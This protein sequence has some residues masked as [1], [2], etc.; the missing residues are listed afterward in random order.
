MRKLIIL[1]ILTS[2]TS[3]AP[4]W[5]EEKPQAGDFSFKTSGH[6]VNLFS[7]SQTTSDKDYASDLQ[8]LRLQLEAGYGDTLKGLLAYDHSLL[9]SS[10]LKTADF[11]TAQNRKRK[12]YMDL[13]QEI[14]REGNLRWE[15]SLYRAYLDYRRD[16]LEV[17][18][19]RQQVPWGIGKFWAPTDVFNPYD[20]FSLEKQER[21]GSDAL[22]FRYAPADS[23]QSELVYAPQSKERDS[24][25][26]L[27]LRFHSDIQ[28]I[29]IIAAQNQEDKVLGLHFMRNIYKAGL[30]SE[31]TRTFAHD[32]PDYFRFTANIDYTFANSLY[33]LG[34]YFYNGQGRRDKFTY[35]GLR[36]T[37]GQIDFLGE[38]LFGLIV[39]YDLTPLIR[40]DNYF[41]FNLLDRSVFINPEVSWSLL[42]NSELLAGGQFF[43]GGAASEFGSYKDLVYLKWK[44]F[45]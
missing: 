31:V 27:R 4:V 10:L 42:K 29:G 5:A 15:H 21:S 32:E 28:E 34:E 24:R 38:D 6:Y 18:I 8:R 1:I 20:P 30:R 26:G 9:V 7:R 41:I 22:N 33:L 36:R 23:L 17:L 43:S 19:G 3:I 13:E 40:S 16:N 35:Q 2:I 37:V 25:A 39:G 11:T 12:R 45:F 14:L 44:T